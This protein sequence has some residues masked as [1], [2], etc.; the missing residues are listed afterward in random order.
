MH[1]H[2]RVVRRQ[3]HSR[4]PQHLLRTAQH[5]RPHRDVHVLPVLRPR[6]P[7]PEVPLVEE[8]PHLPADGPVCG[9]HGA[10]V[11]AALHR[12]QLPE[13][14]RLVD[15]NARRHV[16]LPVQRVLPEHVQSE[17]GPRPGGP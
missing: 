3:V 2:V 14:V 10:R 4:W 13:G 16:L 5:L 15:R 7:V 8:V 1:A 11:P 17:Q 9:N 12:L 6:T